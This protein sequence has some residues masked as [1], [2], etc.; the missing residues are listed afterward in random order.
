[1]KDRVF[2]LLFALCTLGAGDAGAFTVATDP[3]NGDELRWDTESPLEFRLHQDF[4]GGIPVLRMQ[5]MVRSSFEAWTS[6]PGS[7][8]DLVEGRIFRG[9]ACPHAIPEAMR[10]REQEICGA[11]LPDPDGESV[12]FFIE[13]LWPFD[14]AVIGLTTLTWARGGEI[15]DADIALNGLDYAW[16]TGDT[17]VQT[18]FESI[19]IHEIGHF[20]GLA[21]TEE[22]GAVM[23]VDYEQ[24]DLVRT[25]GQDDIDGLAYLYPCASGNCSTQVEHEEPSSCSA[26]AGAGPAALLG[27]ILVLGFALRR[28][29]RALLPALAL[30]LVP[31]S[32]DTSVVLALDATDLAER[33]DAVVRARVQGVFSEMT[34]L[35]WTDVTLAVDEV[36]V[37]EAPDVV[38]L[39]QPG[40]LTD[41]FGT[42]VFGMPEFTEGEDVVVFLEFTPDGP[43]VVG[44]SQ[45][46]A[47]VSK[48]GAL[49]R[50][51]SGL[52]LAR[53]RGE[54]PVHTARM[55]AQL[56]ELRTLLR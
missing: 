45:G 49:E 51:L 52:T 3:G 44:L 30:L 54:G 21:H 17:G 2:L 20:F 39:R 42:M 18:D 33:S 53:R 10:D 19:L 25:L 11:S 12:V 13:T 47:S 40:G 5:G 9:P 32:A 24:G 31:L 37:G 35:V 38:T 48:D 26:G 29:S 4:G 56:S 43:R 22:P 23:R 6:L 1:M 50:D 34:N 8:T 55:P 16:T 36:L 7:D 46:K 27:G 28:R 14:Q 15:V 41:D